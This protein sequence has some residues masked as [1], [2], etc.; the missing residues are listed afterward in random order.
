M[1]KA[2]DFLSENGFKYEFHDYKKLG[3]SESKIK[4]WFK[5]EPWEK[6]INKQ[7]QTFRKL[8]DDEKSAVT[9]ADSAM[10]LMIE[11]TSLIKRPILEI[12]DKLYFG[13]DEKS[14][15]TL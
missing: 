4:E 13:F 6:F 11:K 12:G 9:N 8:S 2:F 15:K 7:G 5:K 14:W 3:I 10:K 1:K